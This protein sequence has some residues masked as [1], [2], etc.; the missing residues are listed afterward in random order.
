MSAG[1]ISPDEH[2]E[3][4]RVLTQFE[5]RFSPAL[6]LASLVTEVDVARADVEEV[7]N[8][9][10]ILKRAKHPRLL[11]ILPNIPATVA[12]SVASVAIEKYEGGSFWPGFFDA[13]GGQVYQ[14]DQAA[15]GEAFLRA[16]DHFDMPTFSGSTRR[17]VVPI[18]AHAGIPNYC[19][20]DYFAALDTAMSR[21]GADASAVTTWAVPRIYT[22]LRAYDVPVRDFLARGDEY[23]TDY[24]DRS[25]DL[26]IR[27][28]RD[29]D[30]TPAML[31]D[32]VV[33]AAR[34]YLES[35]DR[36]GLGTKR[37]KADRVAERSR[38]HLDALDGE[39]K[40]TL[41][42]IANLDEDVTWI[43]TA[44]THESRITPHK[45][46]GGR[47]IGVRAATHTISR[48]ARV[49]RIATQHSQREQEIDLVDADDP[50]VL[51]SDDGDL[52]ASHLPVPAGEVWALFALDPS[53][54]PL[55]QQ[56]ITHVQSPPLGWNGWQ[57]CRVNLVGAQSIQLRPETPSHRVRNDARVTLETITT[58]PIARSG[59]LVVHTARPLLHIP[60]GIDADWHLTVVETSTGQTVVERTVRSSAQVHDT[61]DPFE[62][63]QSPVVGR[64]ALSIRG[65]LGKGMSRDIAVVE[66]LRIRPSSNFRT[67]VQCG[68][69]ASTVSV[70]G[71]GLTV[72]RDV[73]T[74]DAQETEKS[75]IVSG[76][77]GDVEVLVA[78]VSM[79]VA[80]VSKDRATEWQF[81]PISC[82]TED[83]A[84]N[85]LLVRFPIDGRA[86][87]TVRADSQRVLQ[88]LESSTR[89]PSGL[90]AEVGFHAR[91]TLAVLSDTLRAAGA[92]TIV[93][94][95]EAPI[96]ILRIEPRQIASGAEVVNDNVV[97]HGF[98]G[99]DVAARLWSVWEPWREPEDLYFDD[100]GV[101][102][103]P[104]ALRG[105][106][107]IALSLRHQDPWVPVTPPAMPDRAHDHFIALPVGENAATSTIALNTS[108]DIPEPLREDDAWALLVMQANCPRH[109]FPQATIDALT[110]GLTERPA[111]ALEAL[112]L[113]GDS[114]AQRVALLASSNLLWTPVEV[115]VDER[116]M[117]P[118]DEQLAR[119]LGSSPVIGALMSTRHLAKHT[120]PE[121]LPQ[122]WAAAHEVLGTSYR[123]I[124]EGRVDPEATAG[125]LENT[126][127]LNAMPKEQFESMVASMNMVPK[128]LLD[129]D[130]RVSRA[131][132]LF[133][134]RW[135]PSLRDT[136]AAAAD[137]VGLVVTTLEREG[138]ESLVLA[139]KARV[140]TSPNEIP[141]SH[142]GALSLALAIT[143]RMAA[144]GHE[145][146]ARVVTAL[147]PH[148]ETLARHAAQLFA[149]DVV[150]AEAHVA[151]MLES[152]HPR[153][154]TDEFKGDEQ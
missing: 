146:S 107:P 32:R 50:L 15:W 98:S 103:L 4:E 132:A 128:A 68:L 19:L 91:F 130:A 141:A 49:I 100:A 112:A 13:L 34:T 60:D 153:F 119:A 152:E 35:L 78:P 101:S 3:L 1:Y 36:R 92:A 127:L 120:S 93:L 133:E 30:P 88:T 54:E 73:L 148:F 27:L 51:F 104:S 56:R 143:A 58:A 123:E 122:A 9:L 61:A 24:I 151:A 144:R 59:G 114:Q 118:L 97:L 69:Q 137:V 40:L 105:V 82:T 72:H 46:M 129:R 140:P 131:I 7:L 96:R 53:A 124:L 44:E 38:I 126:L 145:P 149:T 47:K 21:V 86:R 85:D 14:E 125:R 11:R 136:N 117:A 16:L 90:D 65:P 94:G 18:L 113:R 84:D 80:L 33:D 77:F 2:E 10:S 22:A 139:I 109:F 106:G 8:S 138:A 57:L 37:A 31:P 71:P 81:T 55:F 134:R 64:F 25:L 95:D 87:A 102:A 63:L 83:L 23:A 76:A 20:G 147:R 43:V 39:V 67:F 75:V 70:S 52:I 79:A 48:P 17:Y 6:H 29:D 116:D 150:L 111:R 62:S 99:G 28:A 42:A 110:S 135:R 26:L 5:E 108:D 89:P 41:P 12:V 45:S 115:P 66:G 74:F 121:Q 142:T 154:G